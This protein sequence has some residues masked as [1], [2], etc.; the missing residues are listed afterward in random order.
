M[1]D[2]LHSLS[3]AYVLDALT[4]EERADFE[5]HLGRCPTCRDEI[6]SLREVAPLLAETV[7]VEPPSS[8][9]ADILAR[10]RET[11]QDPP[12]V[13]PE[14]PQE[15]EEGQREGRVIPLRR[16]WVAL[17]AAAALVV[18]GIATWQVV[19]QATTSVTEQVAEADD[20]QT[21]ETE[22][23]DGATVVITRSEEVGE[24]VLR[25]EGLE[26]PG[27]GRAYQAWLQDDD[28]D[29]ASAGLMGGDGEMVLDGDVMEAEGVGVS[30]EPAEGSDQPTTDPIALVE[31][32]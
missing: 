29:L 7:A 12:A 26:D 21:W 31:L 6:A 25:V 14:T 30:E 24:A 9:R 13:A 11:R 16:R 1:S 32:G 28:G 19:E 3:G 4:D 5:V 2:D 17:A 15:P 10:A 23:D 18:G 27:D 20:A 22:T 8:L